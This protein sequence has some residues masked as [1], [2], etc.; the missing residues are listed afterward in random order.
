MIVEARHPA[1][2]S[3]RPRQKSSRGVGYNSITVYFMTSFGDRDHLRRHIDATRLQT[4]ELVTV[5][6]LAS[7]F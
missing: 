5:S 4:P 1:G 2:S 3:A 6:I 7:R